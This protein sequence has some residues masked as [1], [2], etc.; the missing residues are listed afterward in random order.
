MKTHNCSNI[1]ELF[2]PLR[3]SIF[4]M[5]YRLFRSFQTYFSVR[6]HLITP[7]IHKLT[8][9]NAQLTTHGHCL[10]TCLPPI[11]RHVHTMCTD[12]FYTMFEYISCMFTPCFTKCLHN[13][14]GHIYTIL[15]YKFTLY[16]NICLHNA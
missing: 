14:R 1:R 10:K 9:H 2:T 16:L 8:T 3:M 13:F 7:Q 5:K 12:M 11:W 4:K 15:E 6:K